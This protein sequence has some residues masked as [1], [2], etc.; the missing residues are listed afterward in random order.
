[1]FVKVSNGN[2]LVATTM[3]APSMRAVAASIWTRAELP[4]K[5][6][7]F[8]NLRVRTN[9]AAAVLMPELTMQL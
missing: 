8:S 5:L 9:C 4:M 6:P 1:M 7:L 3:G 2:T